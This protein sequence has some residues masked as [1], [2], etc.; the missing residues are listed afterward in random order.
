MR[1]AVSSFR[2]PSVLPSFRPWFAAFVDG[3]LSFSL[4]TRLGNE[5][6][7]RETRETDRRKDRRK[8][9]ESVELAA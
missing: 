7:E 8:I 6:R 3:A 5:K 1:S 4:L 2:R 9:E